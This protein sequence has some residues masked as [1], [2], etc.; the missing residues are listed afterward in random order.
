MNDILFWD[1]KIM[2]ENNLW[3][4]SRRSFLKEKKNFFSVVP[5]CFGFFPSFCSIEDIKSSFHYDFFPF[6]LFSYPFSPLWDVLLL[7]GGQTDDIQTVR[8]EVSTSK[9]LKGLDSY[10]SDNLHDCMQV[11][12][13]NNRWTKG[14][15]M[16]KNKMKS[17]SICL[18][19][20]TASYCILASYTAIDYQVVFCQSMILNCFNY[21]LSACYFIRFFKIYILCLFN[22]DVLFF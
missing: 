7:T 8:R 5:G 18:F 16:G 22:S 9:P 3:E 15:Q 21:E 11:D 10:R 20:F 1:N 17:L 14:F 2:L 6:I 4:N 13:C 19:N 12:S